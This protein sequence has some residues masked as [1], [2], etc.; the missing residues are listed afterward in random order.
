MRQDDLVFDTE[1][2]LTVQATILQADFF[3]CDKFGEV[4]SLNI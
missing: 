3:V 4:N 1:P 2:M